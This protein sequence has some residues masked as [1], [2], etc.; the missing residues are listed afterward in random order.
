MARPKSADG[1]RVTVAARFSE[2]EAEAITA[3]LGGLTRSA[4]LRGAALAL[5][6]GDAPSQARPVR[7][8]R[9][10]APASVS[11][12]PVSREPSQASGKCSHPKAR[13][14]KG[15]CRVCFAYVGKS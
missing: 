11:S 12:L 6:Q 4:W 13:V 2:A 1:K 5:L 7:Q 3:A 15:Q 10:E 8:R 14:L 9:K